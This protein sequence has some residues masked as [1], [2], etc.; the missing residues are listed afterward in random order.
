MFYPISDFRLR[1]LNSTLHGRSV[2]RP[3]DA[4]G[5]NV[6]KGYSNP[7]T[8]DAVDLFGAAKETVYS[9]A[10]GK[11]T[12]HQFDETMKEVIYFE[13]DGFIAVYAHINKVSSIPIGK[14][15]AADSVIGYLRGDLNDPHLHFE[16]WVDGKSIRGA[17]SG[18]CRYNMAAYLE[19]ISIDTP[20]I[21]VGRD[22]NGN[23]TYTS[24]AI[25]S[26][27]DSGPNKDKVVGPVADVVRSLGHDAVY[28]SDKKLYVY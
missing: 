3:E 18:E 21:K 14:V 12:R 27:P 11:I 2:Y 17:T 10:P 13:G 16:L 9:I 5:H 4:P 25:G 20:I 15:I 6:F 26:I 28:G 7:G 22:E 24:V 8:G 1:R 23:E 19:D